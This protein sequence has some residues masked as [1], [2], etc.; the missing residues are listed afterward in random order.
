MT[1]R[2]WV[3]RFIAWLVLPDISSAAAQGAANTII[4]PAAM[5]PMAFTIS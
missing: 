1:R 2:L 3:R 4:R 5:T